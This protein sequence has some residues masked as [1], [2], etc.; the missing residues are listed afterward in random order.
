MMVS[1]G[2]GNE[3]RSNDSQNR[4]NTGRQF[5]TQEQI[6]HVRRV[7]VGE[8]DM[9]PNPSLQELAALRF[10]IHEQKD[11]ISA[12]RRILERCRDEA[13]AS[14][15][16]W[17]ALSSHYSS[18]VQH[19]TRSHIPPGANTHNVVRN[20]EAEFNEADLLPKT[21][22][23]A[24][25]ATAAYIAP[26]AANG[27]EHMRHLQNLA[28]EGVRVLQGTANQERETTPRRAIPPIEQSRYPA[29]APAVAP[30][31]Q[32]VE[33]INGELRHVLAQNRVDHGRARREAH[34]FEEERDL[35]AFTGNHDGLC[36]A[37]CFSLLIRSTPLPRGIKL[38][39]GVVKFN[40]QQDPR[41]W[42]DDFMTAVTIGGG[43]RDNDLQLLSLHL[44][45]NTRAWLNNLAPDSIRSWE[46]FRQAFIANFRGTS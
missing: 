36:G 20:L 18:N 12:D 45:D 16:R 3:N 24:I 11:Q 27:D 40:G 9:G 25:M 37:E 39:D 41:I 15:R 21:K 14:S 43:S 28:L 8:G 5:I 22:E 17:A 7:Y 38:S 1:H 42:L 29:A 26:N 35:E 31:T 34:R 46:E 10:V 23:A 44:K 30:R 13:D 32:V 4:S 19:R 2:D 33:P 6:R